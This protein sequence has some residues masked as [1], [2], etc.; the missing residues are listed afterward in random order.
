M[1]RTTYRYEPHDSGTWVELGDGRQIP[2][3]FAVTFEAP[4][5]SG[6]PSW[7]MQFR[8]IDGVPQCRKIHVNATVGGREV[9]ASDLRSLR[10]EDVLEQVVGQIAAEFITDDEGVVHAVRQVMN[11]RWRRTNIAAARGARSGARRTITE[12]L[13]R[14]VAMVVQANPDAPAEAVAD[15]FEK[16]LRSARLY[17]QRAREAGHLPGDDQP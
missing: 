12:G 9:H 7:E 13:L 6:E 14:D 3:E 4:K 17:I 11:A 5:G 8:M 10:I 2:A 16:S 15:H 1:R